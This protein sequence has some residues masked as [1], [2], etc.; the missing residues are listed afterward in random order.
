VEQAEFYHTILS[1]MPMPLTRIDDSKRLVIGAGETFVLIDSSKSR[2]KT[3]EGLTAGQTY[4]VYYF[5]G[6]A[7]GVSQLTEVKSIMCA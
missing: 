1:T 2:K 7:R 3:Y 6:N 4:Y 5:I